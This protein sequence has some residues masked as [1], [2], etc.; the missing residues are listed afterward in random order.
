[1]EPGGTAAAPASSP[2]FAPSN[3][4]LAAAAT[5][6]AAA[7]PPP[8][9]GRLIVA[10]SA[11]QAGAEAAAQELAS[12]VEGMAKS[13]ELRRL[14]GKLRGPA[15]LYFASADRDAALSLADRLSAQGSAWSA[16]PGSGRYPRGTLELLP[17]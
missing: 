15:V 2:R 13:V 4:E 17:P 7:S 14:S 3:S 12:K 6:P 5:P 8:S 16:R 1:M 10:Y 11:G 9:F